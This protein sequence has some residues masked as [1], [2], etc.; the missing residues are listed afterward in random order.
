MKKILVS[1]LGVAVVAT[2][3]NAYDA[4]PAAAPAALPCEVA[5]TTPPPPTSPTPTPLTP[6]QN[7]R[8][9]GGSGGGLDELESDEPT[10]SGPWV[11]DRELAAAPIVQSGSHAYYLTLA[12]RSDC[13]R[14]YS[15]RDAA[16]LQ[17]PNNGGFAHS[18]SRPLVVTYDPANDPDPRRQDAAK[19]VIGTSSNSLV[20][21]VRV[22]IPQYSG[23][24]LV[25]W[26]AWFGKEFAQSTSG[27]PTYKNFQLASN[28]AIWT[29]VRSRFSLA[30]GGDI[31]AVDLRY[32][33]TPG[34][35]TTKQGDALAPMTGSFVIK[36]ET[37]T[38]YWVLIKP[39]GQWTEF[40]LWVADA[41]RGPVQLL[42]RSLVTPKGSGA[43]W[44]EFWLE[45]NTSTDTVKPG[46]PPL[47][48]YARN[49]VMLHNV[50]NVGPLL[51]RP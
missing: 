40:S 49:I 43:R 7:L 39:A 11:D 31:A 6:P 24:L 3:T 45:Y 5:T 8:I 12:G 4:A 38:R 32:Y 16:Q 41:T 28:G 1:F 33:G 20:N 37:W 29:E 25:T 42:D 51:Q 30:S 44:D 48:G 18:N 17:T 27:I 34:P 46:R 13:L 2:V 47:V 36:P 21:Q 23:A 35:G 15:L 9:I 50:T 14:A 19:V 26:D 10:G 22:P